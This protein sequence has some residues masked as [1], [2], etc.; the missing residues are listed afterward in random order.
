[1]TGRRD[2]FSVDAVWD[3]AGFTGPAVFARAG[4]R[5]E[6]APGA[7]A[8]TRLG[9]TLFPALTDHHVH[10]GLVEP[11]ALFAGGITRA[12]DLGW[13]PEVAAGWVARGTD[14]PR[15]AGLRVAIAGGLLTAPGGYPA[16]AAWAPPGAAVE[17]RGPAEAREAVRAQ[18]ALGASVIKT[19]L[20]ADAGPTLDDETLRA[21]VAEAHAAGVEVACHAQGPGQTERA[22]AAG[23]DRL[24]HTPYAETVPDAVIER[25]VTAG[26]TW[27]P[28]LDIN[29]WGDRTTTRHRLAF[30][31]LRRFLRAG[32]R[33]LYGTDQG[34]GPLPAGVDGRELELLR[35]AGLTGVAL[36]RSIAGDRPAASVGPTFA[37]VPGA[38]PAGDE[39]P[40]W[41]AH[42]EGRRV[43]EL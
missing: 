1:M 10:L 22:V 25:A 31:N 7:E 33:V 12:V 32:G 38:P 30:D 5:L 42:A 2:T 40:G 20:N 41:L 18:L 36:L 11:A 39:L 4:E 19:T 14:G 43:R 27:I 29:G 6:A 17:V 23:V 16:R 34:N 35:D 28:T 24:A 26:M 13:V 8:G 37:W 21:V 9:G 3:G 15:G